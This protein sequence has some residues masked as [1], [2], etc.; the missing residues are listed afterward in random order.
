M[1]PDS[2]SDVEKVSG[3]PRASGDDPYT[4]DFHIGMQ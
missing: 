2:L 1:I 3:K 4:Y